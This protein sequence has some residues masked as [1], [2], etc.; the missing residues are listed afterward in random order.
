MGTD[1]C[2]IHDWMSAACPYNCLAASVSE[3]SKA[4][5]RVAFQISLY[6]YIYIYIYIYNCN[7]HCI[8]IYIYHHTVQ[9]TIGPPH[10]AVE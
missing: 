2:T 5:D 9:V 8:Y 6:I 3:R 1:A 4:N 7:L 10:V